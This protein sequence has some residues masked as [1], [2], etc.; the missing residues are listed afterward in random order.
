MDFELEEVQAGKRLHY[1]DSADTA[2]CTWACDL[3][4]TT[5]MSVGLLERM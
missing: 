5:K 1:A 3:R 2:I 4:V